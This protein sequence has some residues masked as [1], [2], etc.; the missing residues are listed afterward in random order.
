MLSVG[1]LTQVVAALALSPAL[2]H[3]TAVPRASVCN[4]YSE[5][6]TLQTLSATISLFTRS[7][8]TAPLATSPSSER[9]TRTPCRTYFVGPLIVSADVYADNFLASANQ[10]QNGALFAD[11]TPSAAKGSRN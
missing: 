7:C 1:R 4:G 2:V 5:V 10:D 11:H 9:T 8:V 6:R 3:A